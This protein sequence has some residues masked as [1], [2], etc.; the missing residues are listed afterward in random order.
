VLFDEG[1]LERNGTMKPPKS[2]NELKIPPTVLA[3]FVARIDRLPSD[4]NELLQTPGPDR[5]GVRIEPVEPSDGLLTVLQSRLR[6]RIHPAPPTS[7]GLRG[8]SAQLAEIGRA[9]GRRGRPWSPD[10]L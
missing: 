7:P 8:F 5:T 9:C 2:L 4:E 3:I 1:A 10:Q 6:V